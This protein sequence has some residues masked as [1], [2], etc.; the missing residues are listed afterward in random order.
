MWQHI[1]VFVNVINGLY[2]VF[3]KNGINICNI[4]RQSIN[5]DYGLNV[6]VN[7][8]LGNKT[9]K[10]EYQI[11][12]HC[13]NLLLTLPEYLDSPPLFSGI[14]VSIFSCL[15]SVLYI[16]VRPFSV[17]IVLYIYFHLRFQI[18]PLVTSNFS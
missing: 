10:L 5:K 3:L 6:V 14:R 16:I 17:Y 18:T 13:N 1:V 4:L 15:C 8:K 9:T 7:F 12:Q 2:W 11:I